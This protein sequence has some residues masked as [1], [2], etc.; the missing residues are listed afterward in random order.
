[1]CVC[2]CVC[3]CVLI[4]IY[5]YIYIW[6]KGDARPFSHLYRV[7]CSA[8]SLSL[9]GEGGG[10]GGGR[11]CRIDLESQ[12]GYS[13]TRTRATN[14]LASRVSRDTPDLAHSLA[15]AR[16]R[17]SRH[18]LHSALRF[19]HHFASDVEN[20][21]QKKNIYMFLFTTLHSLTVI[22]FETLTV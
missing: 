9:E 3:M 14:S 13:F 6:P 18:L 20:K 5:I 15:R 22:Q 1:V 2:V 8:L 17:R 11:T 19:T 21:S 16:A 7:P 4:Y 10:R 12:S